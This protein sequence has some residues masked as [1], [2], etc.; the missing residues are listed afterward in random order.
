[1]VPTNA[2]KVRP[3]QNF[4]G[5]NIS[6]DRIRHRHIFQRHLRVPGIGSAVREVWMRNPNNRVA[7]RIGDVT[8]SGQHPRIAQKISHQLLT[9]R[10]VYGMTWFHGK[11]DYYLLFQ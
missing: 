2:R 8:L 5:L 11:C 7:Q 10:R 6:D 9:A 1:M 3:I 4:T